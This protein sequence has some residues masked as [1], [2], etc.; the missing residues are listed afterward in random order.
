MVEAV[1]HGV[2]MVLG[3]SVN[4]D[5]IQQQYAPNHPSSHRI[6]PGFL[7]NLNHR[8]IQLAN[9][10]E[11]W[12]H[13][14]PLLLLSSLTTALPRTCWFGFCRIWVKSA[15]QLGKSRHEN[16]ATTFFCCLHQTVRGWIKKKT[17][18][19]IVPFDQTQEISQNIFTLPQCTDSSPCEGATAC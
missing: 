6:F 14:H 9:N 4:A 1:W 5:F 2:L 15:N 8:A 17:L 13:S 11:L 19:F 18:W 16:F 12:V 10:W 3:W 7:S